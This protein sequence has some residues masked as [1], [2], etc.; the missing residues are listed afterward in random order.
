[1]ENIFINDNEIIKNEVRV[2][3]CKDWNNFSQEIKKRISLKKSNENVEEI[4]D[5][6]IYR[7]HSL[8]EW[9]LSSLLERKFIIKSDIPYID[10]VEENDLKRTLYKSYNSIQK[11]LF[12]RFIYLSNGIEGT[13]L[14]KMEENEIWALGRHYG[15]IT[16]LLDWTESP[17]IAA[18]F[19]FME[20]YNKFEFGVNHDYFF[21]G[22]EY[23]YVWALRY[24]EAIQ[25]ENEFEVIRIPR[26]FG[27]RLWAQAGIF[28]RLY[29]SEHSNIES[30]LRSKGKA[31]FLDCFELPIKSAPEALDDLRRM[32]ITYSKLF[33]DLSGVAQEANIS[34]KMISAAMYQDHLI[35][36]RF[37]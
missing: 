1:M 21:P 35:E 14:E 31:H 20:Q 36:K 15:L 33:P 9:K 12:E 3:T 16:P 23:V 7:G 24:G 6:T 4:Q 32:N 37:R 26:K 17:Y 2:I 28:S 5:K 13:N 25:V 10:P 8:K 11:K 29:T 30:Y 19:A 34:E 27:S 22:K 18:F